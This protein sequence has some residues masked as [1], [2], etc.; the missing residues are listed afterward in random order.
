MKLSYLRLCCNWYQI[1]M[2]FQAWAETSRADTSILKVEFVVVRLFYHC[3]T[4]RFWGLGASG[5]L[6]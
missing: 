1:C 5:V 2:K 6:G 3:I 4:V